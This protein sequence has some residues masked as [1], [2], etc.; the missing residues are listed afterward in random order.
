LGTTSPDPTQ[1]IHLY[2][3]SA[4]QWLYPTGRLLPAG[5]PAW[6]GVLMNRRSFMALFGAAIAFPEQPR[7]VATPAADTATPQANRRPAPVDLGD[8]IILIDYRVFPEET[9]HNR[10]IGEIRNTT[11][12]MIDSPVVS[13]Y[14]PLD[15]RERAGFAYATPLLPVIEAGGTVPIFGTFPDGIDPE[16]ALTAADFALCTTA[17]PGQYTEREQELSLSIRKIDQLISTGIYGFDGEVTNVGDSLATGTIIRGIIRDA[18]GRVAGT[19]IGF[20]TNVIESGSTVPFWVGA[21]SIVD[22]RAN[23][24]IQLWGGDYTADIVAG[25]RGPAVLPGCSFGKPWE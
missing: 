2:E 9:P 17:E 1:D 15:G 8:G 25:T 4:D 16:A 3:V 13:L 23:P 6:Q 20:F 24:V 12:R 10:F 7:M 22:H 19:T 18:D 11:D 14:Y 21:G 5:V